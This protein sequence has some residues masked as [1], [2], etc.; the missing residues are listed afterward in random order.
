MVFKKRYKPFYKQFS[1]LRVNIQNRSKLFKFKKQKW[2]KFQGYS[3]SQLKFFKRY[4]FKDQFRVFVNKFASRGN[5]FQK[6][7]KN[8][9]QERKIFTLFYGGL[10][11]KYFKTS[12]FKLIN[13]KKF[14]KR[15]SDDL[16]HNVVQ[17]FESRLDTVLYR[18]GFCL[19]IKEARKFILH[20]HVLVNK[21][22]VTTGSFNL[23]SNDLIE[24]SGNVKSRNWVKQNLLKFNFWLIPSKHLQINYR[25][26]Q[27][28]FLYTDSLNLFP[29]FN[30]YLNL[31]SVVDSIK[32][33]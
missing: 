29:T 22:F 23:K 17:F 13:S 24:I 19:S 21:T 4:K 33:Y 8:N 12:V 2:L 18:S 15:G 31:T 26:L 7:F 9:L 3:K 28:L 10:K 30:H 27:I 16:K 32:K 1:R 11:R 20:K 25:T 6:K 14:K 5:S